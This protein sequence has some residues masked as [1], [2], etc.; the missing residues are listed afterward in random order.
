VPAADTRS[1]IWGYTCANDVTARDLGRR[2]SSWTQAKS[3]DTFCPLGPWVST[4]LDGD[5]LRITTTVNGTVR[6]KDSTTSMTRGVADLVSYVSSIM[7]LLPGDV[8][9]TGTPPGNGPVRPGDVVSVAI[10]GIGTLGNAVA[11]D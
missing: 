7:T 11:E 9:L 4:G 8:I 5:D 10:D 1:V 3:F 2:T 6:Q